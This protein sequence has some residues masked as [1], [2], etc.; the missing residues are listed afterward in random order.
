MAFVCNL[1]ALLRY[2][3]TEDKTKMQTLP[4]FS[5][6]SDV[7][8]T[9]ENPGTSYFLK[10]FIYLTAWSFSCYT[11]DLLCGVRSGPAVLWA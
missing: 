2:L 6:T 4:I 8:P 5:T 7:C 9:H 1:P 11:K 10:L 3:L